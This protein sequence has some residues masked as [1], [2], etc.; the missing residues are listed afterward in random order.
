MT[1]TKTITV[2]R[3]EDYDDDQ[4]EMIGETECETLGDTIVFKLEDGKVYIDNILI[5]TDPDVANLSGEEKE[6]Y[7]ELIE[8]GTSEREAKIK[9]SLF[10]AYTEDRFSEYDFDTCECEMF[11][12]II[13]YLLGCYDDMPEPKD[14]ITINLFNDN[15]P[16]K[17]TDFLSY[18][19]P[20]IMKEK[21]L[22]AI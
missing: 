19:F 10:F 9:A 6:L 15:K 18:D 3:Y 21:L 5:N 8:S 22:N 16:F 7:D 1:T 2:V 14:S 4:G 11:D 13:M 17:G 12:Y 20:K